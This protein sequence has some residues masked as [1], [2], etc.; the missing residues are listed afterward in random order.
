MKLTGSH[1]KIAS[2]LQKHSDKILKG[3]MISIDPGSKSPGWALWMCGRLVDSG[4]IKTKSTHNISE[5][6][7][8]ISD[9]LE[10]LPQAD[11]VIVEKIGMMT[12]GPKSRKAQAHRFL[13][14]SLGAITAA[15]R[16]DTV[17]EIPQTL[18][19]KY[20]DKDYIKSDEADA[21]MLGKTAKE[22]CK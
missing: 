3:T 13:F 11:I 5:R 10:G 9:F 6:L 18:W 14:W 19:R 21:I 8:S 16:C 12:G 20:R 22:L 4:V 2:A 1:Q 17:V 7:A 15:V